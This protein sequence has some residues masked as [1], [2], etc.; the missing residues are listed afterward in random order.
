MCSPDTLK[1]P[2]PD[3]TTNALTLMFEDPRATP[4]ADEDCAGPDGRDASD[5][6]A[7]P[8]PIVMSAPA[9]PDS[10]VLS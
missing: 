2:L 4:C 10:V 3:L 9:A 7:T 6:L 1:E 5:E 8:P